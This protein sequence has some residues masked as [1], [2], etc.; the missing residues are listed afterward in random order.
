M[1]VTS[2]VPDVEY[3]V[4]QSQ[5]NLSTALQQLS[6]GLRVNQ[7]SDD[8]VA[9]A[10]M[11]I[12]LA[13]SANV[14]EYTTNVTTV[15][16]QLQTSDNAIAAVITSL[17]SAITLATA[18]PS[19][20]ITAANRQAIAA[21]VAGVLQNVISQANSSY[22]GSFL[23]AGSASSGAPFV[24]AS[25]AYTSQNG[26]L[27]ASSPL[28]AGSVTTV[29][30][31]A[32]GQTFTYTAAAGD[33]V[34]DLESAVSAAVTAGTLSSGTSATINSSGELAISS[35]TGLVAS[36][37][38]STLGSVSASGTA[39][40][41][42]YAY[43]GD[44]TVNKVQVGDSTSVATNIPGNQL[45]TSGASVIGSLTTLFNALQSGSD[46]SIAAASNGISTAIDY[47]SEQRI[48]L[49]STISR[50]SDQESYLSQETLTLTTHQT[51]LVGADL[52]TAATNLSQAELANS[53]VLAAA[54]KVLPQTLLNYLAP[55]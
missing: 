24:A 2:M 52:A 36:S 44:S 7:P 43:V 26:S 32:T 8:P 53:A 12:S 13:Q 29:S 17:N 27:T 42:A 37:T 35:A 48:P 19:S 49:D 5:Q 51:A 6:T 45:F 25:T 4:Q 40:T 50:L 22:Q 20:T 14:D 55:G 41:N 10:S 31:A 34:G 33:T 16:G 15:S 23:F 38:D 30:D 18:A 9:S 1:R 47:L 46:S 28:E 54:S 39:L 11:V 21:Q 3:A